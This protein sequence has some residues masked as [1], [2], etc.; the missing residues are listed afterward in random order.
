MP[1][2]P[3]SV[4]KRNAA[5]LSTRVDS[6]IFI[7]NPARDSYVGLDEIG[8]RVWDLLERPTTVD[9]LCHQVAQEYQGD[10]VQIP[11]DLVAFLN[12]LNGEGLLEV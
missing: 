3:E 8:R 2:T 11:V 1:L 6:D 7:L 5:L 10:P 4:V 9:Q 12:E